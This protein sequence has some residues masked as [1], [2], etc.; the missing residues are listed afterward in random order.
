MTEK[1][2]ACHNAAVTEKGGITHCA[3]CGKECETVEGGVAT[4]PTGGT[5]PTAPE[6]VKVEGG[7]ATIGT[8]T[9]QGES[10]TV[11]GDEDSEDEESDD[12]DGDDADKEPEAV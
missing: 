9:A 11:E 3:V 5:M 8:D 4:A 1:L 12:E 6:A 7:E 10:K 2:S